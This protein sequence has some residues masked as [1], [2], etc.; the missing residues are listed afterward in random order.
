M[1]YLSPR[2]GA[3]CALLT[4]AFSASLAFAE[5]VKVAFIGDQG[6]TEESRQ[7]LEL[8]RDEGTE[9]LLIQGDLGYSADA[10]SSWIDNIDGILGRDFP[11]LI[12]V[13]NH[14]NFEWPAYLQWQKDKLARVD[15]IRCDGDISVKAYCTYKDIGVVQVAPGVYEVE[16]VDGDDN[17][18]EFI[19]QMFASD[20]STWRIC[21][22]HKNMRDMQTGSK[23]DATGWGVYQSCL[24]EGGLVMTGHEHAYSRTHLMSS[25]EA[26]T[27]IHKSSEMEIGPQ[28][29]LAVVSGLGGWQIRPQVHGG[30]WFASVYSATQNANYGAL[31]CT[32]DNDQ[33]DCY[34]KDVAGLVPDAFSL[35]S[36]LGNASSEDNESN[37]SA[38]EEA[39]AQAETDA[40]QAAA[41]QQAAAEEQ[42]AAEQAEANAQAEAEAAELAEAEAAAQARS[43]LAEAE[44]ATQAEPEALEKLKR[45]PLR[46]PK[47][48]PELAEA[49][50]AASQKQKLLNWLET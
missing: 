4:V 33:A 7:V 32:F 50:A 29:S 39:E 40:A 27:I 44:A 42:A 24:A 5:P 49:E 46:K 17:Y 9:L 6:V 19:T 10:A 1:Q 45:K 8:I 25:F 3:A 28:S 26:K 36:R 41:E 11:V 15:S 35:T 37:N 12:V 31:F 48:K 18:A 2:S 22:W 38:T 30:D 13:G 23:S 47:Q 34:M 16:G 20:N 43:R 14:E 21:S